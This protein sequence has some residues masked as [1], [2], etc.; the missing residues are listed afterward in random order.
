VR[1]GAR[2][3]EAVQ[4]GVAEDAALKSAGV[5]QN[6]A[7]PLKK[8]LSRHSAD[9]WL[10]ML[11]ACTAIDRQIKGQARG[12]HWDALA[13]LVAQLAGHGEVLMKRHPQIPA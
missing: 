6:R 10:S 11:S 12:S 8:A 2:A 13:A 4:A 3:A 9:A 5:W 7:Q 1:A